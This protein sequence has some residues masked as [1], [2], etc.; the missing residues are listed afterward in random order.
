MHQ[1]CKFEIVVLT[2]Q[3][4]ECY[5][6]ESGITQ[7]S[8]HPSTHALCS[9]KTSTMISVI[10]VLFGFAQDFQ[11]NSYSECRPAVCIAIVILF[12][13]RAK[14]YKFCHIFNFHITDSQ[15]LQSYQ[16]YKRLLPT[17]HNPV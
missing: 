4:R 8:K 2:Y 7:L 5:T 10:G 15:C 12:R 3:E 6:H 11:T 1:V 14:I 9:P 16:R 17:C 13:H